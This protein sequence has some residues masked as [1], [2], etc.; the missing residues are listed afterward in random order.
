M[1][2]RIYLV[3][4]TIGLIV[5]ILLILKFVQDSN[6]ITTPLVPSEQDTAKRVVE[7]SAPV[8]Q[9]TLSQNQKRSEDRQHTARQHADDQSAE[10][11]VRTARSNE[12]MEPESLTSVAVDEEAPEE[13]VSPE[14]LEK[15]RK[16]MEW[17]Q[18]YLPF[19]RKLNTVLTQKGPSYDDMEAHT[20]WAKYKVELCAQHIEYLRKLQAIVPEAVQIHYGLPMRMFN[21]SAPDIIDYSQVAGDSTDFGYLREVIFS[22]TLPSEFDE[23]GQPYIP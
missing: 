23:L 16:V 4:G 20:E 2:K 6:R 10:E 18:E 19:H 13:A 17:V 8:G 7:R 21:D 1:N 11:V 12:Q 5:V 22:G 9:P 14:I 3:V 15:R